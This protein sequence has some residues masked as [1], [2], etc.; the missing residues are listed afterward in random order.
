MPAAEEVL[1][2]LL[3][4]ASDAR[5]AEARKLTTF[6]RLLASDGHGA[7]AGAASVDM[8]R[9]SSEFERHGRRR[10]AA[11][12]EDLLRHHLYAALPAWTAAWFGRAELDVASAWSRL[13]E[14]R[15]EQPTIAHVP[16]PG[17]A[18]LAV[19]E[20]LLACLGQ[21]TEP[22]AL[23]LWHARFVRAAEG[24]LA[25]EAA[26]LA[27]RGQEHGSSGAALAGAIEC[28]LDLGRVA[29]ARALLEEGGAPDSARLARLGDW[30]RVLQGEATGALRHADDGPL[31]LPIVEWREASPER[32]VQLPGRVPGEFG[33]AGPE[34]RVEARGMFGAC[35]FGV[36]VFRPGLGAEP[37]LLDVAPALVDTSAA[38]LAAREGAWAEPRE[39]EH[40]VVVEAEPQVVHE[41]PRGALSPS[42]RAL[43]L[44]PIL[45]G[46][47]EVAGWLYI[48]CE[49]ELLPTRARLAALAAA[50][51]E[52]LLA[53]RDGPPGALP[54]RASS[55]D[56]DAPRPRPAA[57]FEGLLGTLGAKFANRRWWGM[58][59]LGEE[60][61]TVA[62]G[63]RGL[64]GEGTSAS[65][66]R[67]LRR[68]LAT[69]GVVRFDEPDAR[70]SI[71]SQAHS[72]FAIPLVV[73]GEVVALFACE[74]ASRRDFKPEDVERFA[75]RLAP[76]ALKLRIGQFREWHAERFGFDVHFDAS[77]P[78]FRAFS[79]R[80]I[81]AGRT[82]TPVVIAGPVGVGKRVLA[83]WLHFESALQGGAFC[84]H[85]CAADPA[86]P[87]SGV[88]PGTVLLTH[89]EGGEDAL[90]RELLARIDAGGDVRWIVTLGSSLAEAV[91]AG[92]LRADLAERLD[93]LQMFLPGLAE[94]RPEIP[95]YVRFLAARFAEEEG[96]HA[97]TFD[98]SAIALLWRQPWE[99]NLRSLGNLVYKLVLLHG[100]EQ[101]G[102]ESIL[103]VAAAH[104]RDLLVRLPSRQPRR[105]DLLAALISTRRV[106]GRLNKTRASLFLGWDP[107]TLVARLGDAGVTEKDVD[108]LGAWGFEKK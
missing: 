84:S 97:P 98:E 70:L 95:E 82:R 72:G 106:G 7:R 101:L 19:A 25:G 92:D 68:V 78:A 6:L 30:C 39:L 96:Q 17:E 16:A 21:Y 1:Q 63:G 94:R 10:L 102:A 53:Q 74:S 104:G 11:A 23:A 108:G 56:V 22:A 26:F 89:V 5:L 54:L 55:A 64:T 29:G 15:G 51:R 46:A 34:A 107:D 99:G 28:R 9:A 105:S 20:R 87:E 49:H 4:K 100:G 52:P 38:W 13:E 37:F 80:L 79:D 75:A 85:D 43:A 93:R 57:L 58:E 81:A 24:P 35:A 40:R 32:V 48:E 61:R 73:R 36:F 103:R 65:G 67:I 60:L 27:C 83:R 31:P 77:D 45:D 69:R 66:A 12:L 62:G 91:E 90:Q 47:G 41:G 33:V 8:G 76:H 18:P 2:L 3:P 14:Y 44:A 88:G 59:V 42:A 50:W 86:W 71:H